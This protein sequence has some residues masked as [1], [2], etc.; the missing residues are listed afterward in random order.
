MSVEHKELGNGIIVYIRI[1]T[2]LL[3]LLFKALQLS[4]AECERRYS[5]ITVAR[6]DFF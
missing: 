2:K 4:G 5:G 3:S 6:L 1:H